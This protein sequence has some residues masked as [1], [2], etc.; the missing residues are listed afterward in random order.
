[1]HGGCSSVGRLSE[2]HTQGSEFSSEH[3]KM[4]MMIHICYSTTLE[5]EVGGLEV[6]GHSRLQT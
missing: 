4:N 2:E 6:Q 3:H 1:M 5:G